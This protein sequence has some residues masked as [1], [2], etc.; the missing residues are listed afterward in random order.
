MNPLYYGTCQSKPTKKSRLTDIVVKD[1]KERTC[2]L[3]DMSVPT[4]RNTSMKMIKTL[5]KYEH[6]EIDNTSGNRCSWS[7]KENN[8]KK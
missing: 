2:L 7:G 6:L 4:E 5:S 3:I 8:R 1:M